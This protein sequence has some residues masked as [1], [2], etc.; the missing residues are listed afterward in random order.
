MATKLGRLVTYYDGLPSLKSNDLL[1]TWSPE[2]MKRTIIKNYYITTVTMPMATKVARM[3]TYLEGCVS[4][5]S[6]DPPIIG[7]CKIINKIKTFY[8]HYH[9]AYH[10]QT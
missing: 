2:I 8:L 9:N 10:K 7:S 5:K 4:I 3:V 6:H 1:N